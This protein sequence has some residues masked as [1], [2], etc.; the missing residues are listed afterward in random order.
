MPEELIT[1]M[2][3]L[4]VPTMKE[5]SPANVTLDTLAMAPM[6]HAQVCKY[7]YTRYVQLLIIIKWPICGHIY[8]LY[9]AWLLLLCRGFQ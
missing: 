5:L 4:T 7:T 2:P 3:M 8:Y 1:V 6:A 9:V